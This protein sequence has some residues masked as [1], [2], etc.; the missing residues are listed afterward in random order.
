M[1]LS[2]SCIPGFCQRAIA[3]NPL[4]AL[5]QALPMSTSSAVE[6]KVVYQKILTQLLDQREFASQDLLVSCQTEHPVVT[7]KIIQ[8]LVEEGTLEHLPTPDPQQSRY[9]WSSETRDFDIGSWISNNVLGTQITAAPV[10]DRPR[11]RLLQQGPANLKLSELL[12]ILIRSGRPGESA[13][14]AGE[15]IA[16]RISERLE[17]LPDLGHPELKEISRAVTEPAYCQIMAGIELGRRVNSAMAHTFN[18]R[19]RIDSPAAA[20]RYCLER[21]ER[22]AREI[23]QEEFHLVSLDTKNQP[24]ASH[25][26]TVGTLRN[27][28]VHPREVF[29]AA[30]R[31]AANCILVVHNHPSGDPTPSDQDIFVTER[32]E[33]AADIV[34]IPLVDHIIVAGPRAISIQQ[35]RTHQKPMEFTRH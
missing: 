33:K 29:R 32:L 2:Q 13:L 23:K 22:L 21:F 11:E 10:A 9:R 30:I 14:Q 7:R 19:T 4:F 6:R 1:H 35:W 26:I 20:I 31:D 27:S 5:P 18:D 12:A 28:L 34:G 16:V 8:Q 17:Q 24:I 25:Q 15:K 3:R